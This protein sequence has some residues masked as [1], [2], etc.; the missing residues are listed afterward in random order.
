MNAPNIGQPVLSGLADCIF[1]IE[2]RIAN[3]PIRHS[4]TFA[5]QAESYSIGST[6][7]ASWETFTGKGIE[8][9]ECN[10]FR[11]NEKADTLSGM[12]APNDAV[13]LRL[14]ADSPVLNA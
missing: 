14:L 10:T 4:S 3:A 12:K 7:F 9:Q 6:L 13:R 2:A 1:G 5:L 8:L 11:M